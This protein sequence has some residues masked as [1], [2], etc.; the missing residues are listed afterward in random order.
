MKNTKTSKEKKKPITKEVYYKEPI[1]YFPEEI[2]KKC[3]L[4]EYAKKETRN[5]KKMEN[6]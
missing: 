3:G 1:S 2:R 6:K 4:G 5:R